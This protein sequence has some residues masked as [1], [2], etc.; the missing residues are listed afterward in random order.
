MPPKKRL[1]FD[2]T[3]NV[4]TFI[5]GNPANVQGPNPFDYKAQ[6]EKDNQEVVNKRIKS[7]ALSPERTGRLSNTQ[8]AFSPF[9]IP[10]QI[11]TEWLTVK[12]LRAELAVRGLPVS[13][14]KS[15]LKIRLESAVKN[16][17]KETDTHMPIKSANN[18]SSASR[19]K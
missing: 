9:M 19:K 6:D 4:Q 1:Q 3:E 14:T 16:E 17:K 5:K 13:G 11:D 15:E 2:D 12:E 18:L 7:R 8:Q 10:F